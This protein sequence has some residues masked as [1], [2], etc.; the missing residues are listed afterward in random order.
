MSTKVLVDNI[1]HRFNHNESRLYLKEKYTN[2]LTI[3]YSGGMFTIT[4][5]LIAFLRN[6]TTGESHEFLVDIY[7][8]PV[9][10]DREE[11]LKIATETYNGAMEQWH[12]EYQELQAK[13]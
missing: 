3:A 11:F 9:K 10:V 4:P 7:N 12:T 5:Q 13:R 1:K 6:S 8:N 2:R